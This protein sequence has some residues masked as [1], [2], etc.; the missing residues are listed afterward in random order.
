MFSLAVWPVQQLCRCSGP[1]HLEISKSKS[2]SELPVA[3]GRILS[4][5]MFGAFPRVFWENMAILLAA[6]LP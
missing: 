3:P 4:P 1:A 6:C 2:E 5:T